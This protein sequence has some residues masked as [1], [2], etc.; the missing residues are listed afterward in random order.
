MDKLQQNKD[1]LEKTQEI[2]KIGSWEYSAEDGTM[3]WSGEMYRILGLRPAQAA[4][5]IPQ[6]L[7][8]VH[9][10]DR[11][12]VDKTYSKSLSE[13]GKHDIEY[14]ISRP[15]GEIRHIR[16]RCIQLQDSE[17]KVT[18]SVGFLED[19]TAVKELHSEL[20]KTRQELDQFAQLA[21]HDLQEPLRA[22]TGFL[23]L[24]DLRY[25]E[26]LDEKGKHFIERSLKAAGRMELLIKELLNLARVTS[27]GGEF[28]ETDL[29]TIFKEATK[30]LKPTMREENA[31]ISCDNL[32][33]LPVDRAQIATLFR[34][35]I[36]NALQYN[37]HKEPAL[38]I[39]CRREGTYYHFSFNDNGIGI[40]PKFHKRIFSPF[41]RLHHQ[42]QFPGIGMGLTIGK[43][44]VERHGGTIWVDSAE[45][46]GA[47]FHFT[48][49]AKG[50]KSW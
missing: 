32:P 12:S 23:Q 10:E 29:N 48:L 47:T 1:A 13:G 16:D 20:E 34:C 41:Q 36:A 7:A 37:E 9:E 24:L 17:G 49:P 31:L 15:D 44:I 8:V 27:R 22:I 30:R 19:I 40:D 6:L 4:L 50:K 14:R 21:S 3:H 26:Q 28:S 38:T 25:R 35:L 46:Q 33:V 2:A 42:R 45:G 11:R 5:G 18:Y 39:S 43:K